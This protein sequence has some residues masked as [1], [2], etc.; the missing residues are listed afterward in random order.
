MI[1]GKKRREADC[2]L[3]SNCIPSGAEWALPTLENETISKLIFILSISSDL[4]LGFI[5]FNY[6]QSVATSTP[7]CIQIA[8]KLFRFWIRSNLYLDRLS[9]QAVTP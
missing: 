3:K 8:S 5:Y 2:R 4:L 7:D 9:V 1:K 6:A